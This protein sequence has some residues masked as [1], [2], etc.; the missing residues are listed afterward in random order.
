MNSGLAPGEK[1]ADEIFINASLY[2]GAP[3]TSIAVR[4]RRILALG[5]TGT[6]RQF[7]AAATRICDLHGHFVMPG[8]NDAHAHLA[9]GGLAKLNVDLAGTRSLSEMQERIAARARTTGPGEWLVGRGWDHTVWPDRKLPTRHHLDAVTA[10]HPAIFSRVDGHLAVVNTLA[11]T[12]CGITRSTENPAGGAIDRG[13]DSEPTGVLRESAQDLVRSKIPKLSPAQ[14]RCAIELALL[15]A[16]RSGVTSIQDNS[17]WEDFLIYEDLEREGKLTAR[18]TEWLPF[19]S[20]LPLLL[21]RREYRPQRDAMLHIGMLKAFLDGSLGSSTAALLAPYHDDPH[22]SGV[23]N[24]EFSDLVAK[25]IERLRAGFQMGF[26]AIGDR[27]VQMALDAI[28]EAQH[29]ARERDIRPAAGD[30]RFR[31][32]HAQVIAPSQIARFREL[33]VVASVQPNHLLTDMNWAQSRLGSARARSSYPWKSFLDNGVL[34]AFGT[35]YPVEPITPFRGLY[36]AVTRANEAGTRDYFPEQRLTI[37]QA[38]AAYTTGSAY[39]EFAE[40][41]K[42]QLSPG[43]LADFVVLDRDIITASPP[44]ILE[45]E[46]LRTV[47]NGQTVYEK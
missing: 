18:I 23:L 22:N 3:A 10:G 1:P 27:A 4:D 46:V 42:G 15:D 24:Y 25:M 44:E 14:R 17:S 13:P 20:P 37:Q 11:L 33:N 38:I 36:A 32:E 29:C 5:P 30:F 41:D 16:A 2:T 39:A 6:T 35:D 19:D 31:I 7:Q 43:M 40:K 21:E 45:T 12:A 28:S 47:V 26:H 9:A 34:L 8:F